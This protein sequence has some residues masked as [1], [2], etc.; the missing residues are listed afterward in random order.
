[1]RFWIQN[2]RVIDPKTG[3]CNVGD[4]VI[5]NGKIVDVKYPG[6]KPDGESLDVRGLIVAPGLVDMHCHLREPGQTHKEDIASGTKSAAK[7]GFTSIACMP[8]TTPPLD[9][10]EL[11]SF[12][13]NA[14]ASVHVYPFGSVSCGMKGEQMTDFAALKAAGAVGVSDDGL[15]VASA[16]MMRDTLVLAKKVG[17]TVTSHCEEPTLKDGVIH[18]GVVA[19][20]LGVAGITP[21]AEE[22]MV[23]REIVLASTTGAP[24][25]IAHISTKGSVELI[26]DAKARGIPVT[27]ETCPHYFSL[28]DEICEGRSANAKMNPPLRTKEDVRAIIEGLC[29]GTID[30]IATDHAPHHA[31]EKGKGFSAAPNGI[32]G[33]ETA[34]SV[35]ITS[36]VRPGYMTMSEMLSKFTCNPAEILG[37]PAGKLEQNAPA[38]LVIFDPEEEWIVSEADIASKSKNTPYLN[39]HLYG[40]V[41]YTIVDGKIVE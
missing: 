3:L 36:L 15:P 13:K 40:K 22:C 39:Y 30:A 12:V 41:K 37:I 4:I 1:M 28:T 17:L 9:S 34:L 29:D 8:N 33:F 31:D 7:G 32:I 10:A 5:E 16:K 19:K 35:A 6:G 24:V 23:A 26:R 27:A 18:D 2:G 25:H 38:D 20:K 11:I 14:P 21:A